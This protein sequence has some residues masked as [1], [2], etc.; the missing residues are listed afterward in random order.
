M[1]DT[2]ETKCL[3]FFYFIFLFLWA[4]PTML[5]SSSPLSL[6]SSFLASI[7]IVL[8]IQISPECSGYSRIWCR[9]TC[10][11]LYPARMGLG[12]IYLCSYVSHNIC[13]LYVVCVR[14][15]YRHMNVQC[16]NLTCHE[17]C[18][19]NLTKE[20]RKRRLTH[21]QQINANGKMYAIK[22]LWL[23]CR[24]FSGQHSH[25]SW[26]WRLILPVFLFVYKSNS[27]YKFLNSY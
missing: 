9:R 13:F 26:W 15:L 4:V 25:W 5:L 24:A 23:C 14:S 18:N 12:I 16:M 17:I 7:A 2:N 11:W 22:L 20:T 10:R 21:R 8:W 19:K 6:L 1:G 27:Y 3:G